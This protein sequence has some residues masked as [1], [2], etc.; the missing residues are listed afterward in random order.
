M[1]SRIDVSPEDIAKGVRGDP[2]LCPVARAVGRAVPDA[3]IAVNG[4]SI[5]L[6]RNDCIDR[7]LPLP[8]AARDFI[9][10]FDDREAVGDYQSVLRLSLPRPDHG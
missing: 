6:W 4:Y 2:F 9:E 5:D 1:L 8:D 7:S 3:K 10:A